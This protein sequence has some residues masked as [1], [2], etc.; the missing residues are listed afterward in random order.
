MSEHRAYCYR[1]H[2]IAIDADE[3][4]PGCWRWSFAIDGRITAQGQGGALPHA[5]AALTK[6]LGAARCR[7]D[8]M[9]G[10][11]Q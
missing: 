5:W 2:T 7:V 10:A 1:G 8:S 9:E 11:E 6:G 4:K 3:Q